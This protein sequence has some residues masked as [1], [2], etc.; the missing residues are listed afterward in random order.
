MKISQTHSILKTN[1]IKHI[2]FDWGDTLMLDDPSRDDAMYQWPTVYALEGAERALRNL[3]EKY[4]I[5]VATNAAKSDEE[6]VRKALERV[7]LSQYITHVYTGKSL[8]RK[9]TEREFWRL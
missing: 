1:S 7:S 2:V 8:G 5:S 3:S 4:T 9:K 6:M